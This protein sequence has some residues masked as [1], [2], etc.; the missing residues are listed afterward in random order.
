MCPEF[1]FGYLLDLQGFLE[2]VLWLLERGGIE[3]TM[4]FFISGMPRLPSGIFG[5]LISSHFCQ[6]YAPWLIAVPVSSDVLRWWLMAGFLFLH[7][8]L[9]VLFPSCSKR[10]GWF[11]MCKC[12]YCCIVDGTVAT[13]GLSIFS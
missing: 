10:P 7:C 6:V 1:P 11:F 13:Y 3:Q 9:S 8:F 12:S 5:H 4:I 2:Q